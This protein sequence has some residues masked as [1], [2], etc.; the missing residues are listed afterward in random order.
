MDFSFLTVLTRSET[1]PPPDPWMAGFPLNYYYFGHFLVATL[2]KLTGVLPQFAYNLAFALWP[3]LVL[4]LIFSLLYNLTKRYFAGVIGVVFATVLGNL[5]GCFLLIDW[6]RKKEPVYR[7]FRPAHEVI[8]Y[9]VHEFPFWTFI[10]VDLHAHLLN[11]PFLITTLLFGLHL[12][13]LKG[14]HEQSLPVPTAARGIETGLTILILGTLGVIS[15]W[16]Y[17]TGVIFL[18]LIALLNCWQNRSRQHRSW[19]GTFK[20][21]GYVL[22]VILPG[23]FTAYLPFYAGFSRSG[24][25]LGLVG[26]A[27]TSLSDFL[28][29]FGFF[30]FCILSYLLYIYRQPHFSQRSWRTIVLPLIAAIV[31]YAALLGIMQVNY[32]VLFFALFLLIF[33]SSSLLKDMN[34]ATGLD[35]RTLPQQLFIWVCLSY[36]CLIVIGC[37]VIFVRDFLQGG[38]EHYLLPFLNRSITFYTGDY[39]RMNTIFKFYIPAWFL[40]SIAAAY[41]VSRLES[42]CSRLKNRWGS[43]APAALLS[44]LLKTSPAR[45]VLGG[46][47]LAAGVF[48]FLCAAVFPV[49]GIYARRHQQDV[50]HRTYFAPTLDGLAYLSEIKPD[51]YLAIRWLQIHVAG[52]PVILEAPGADYLYEYA[53]ISAN[54]G[55]PTVLG[56]RSHADQREHWHRTHRREQDVREIYTTP[57][58]QRTMQ[59]LRAYHVQYIYIGFTER[60]D[61]PPEQLQKFANAPQY[62]EKVFQSGDTIIYR[63]M[64]REFMENT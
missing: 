50:Y 22:A 7:F 57:N 29:I 6:L 8:P 20:P 12:L 25:G 53:R 60:R 3:A 19:K 9:T 11:M 51:E 40:F 45:G 32:A 33:G 54:S 44:N 17:P 52:T 61:F 41:S 26:S 43:Y 1:L 10:F 46:V 31:L 18:I 15:S 47:W 62:F 16:D 37:E 58:L 28:T 39:K 27:T 36:A 24:M 30:L 23:S 48:F 55:L 5:D 63:I 38:K 21:L 13:L 49:M 34:G 64:F 42:A 56:W 2:T 4:V 35:P 14:T 59:L